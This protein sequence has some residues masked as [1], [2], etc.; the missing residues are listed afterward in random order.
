M[1]AESRL[2]ALRSLCEVREAQFNERPT[3]HLS[4]Y[5]QGWNH[6]VAETYAEVMDLIDGS[7]SESLDALLGPRKD[8]ATPNTSPDGKD[9]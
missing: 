5:L 2:H 8:G 7:A 4:S 1:T 6:G 3:Q 9:S